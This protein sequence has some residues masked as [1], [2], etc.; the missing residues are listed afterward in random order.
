MTNYILMR[1]AGPDE[2]TRHGK[3]LARIKTVIPRP[4]SP[5]SQRRCR[6]IFG[7]PVGPGPSK[8]HRLPGLCC[9]DHE[10]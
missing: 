4:T 7:P 8:P 6:G 3:L 9:P 1:M 5:S 10:M 2:T